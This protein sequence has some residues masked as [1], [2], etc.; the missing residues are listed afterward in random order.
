MATGPFPD[1]FRTNP[2][3][4]N[5]TET[6]AVN[7]LSPVSHMSADSRTSSDAALL[8]PVQADIQ[9][10]FNEVLKEDIVIDM[11]PAQEG[12]QTQ[13]GFSG[14]IK[15]GVNHL[16]GLNRT[17]EAAGTSAKMRRQESQ[18]MLKGHKLAMETIIYNPSECSVFFSSLPSSVLIKRVYCSS[19]RQPSYSILGLGAMALRSLKLGVPSLPLALSNKRFCIVYL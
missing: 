14:L 13:A 16:K 3:F 19:K 12:S 5:A 6:T 17:K 11:G 9:A 4:Q 10:P 2:V 8:H 15:S 18:A 7:A 1:G